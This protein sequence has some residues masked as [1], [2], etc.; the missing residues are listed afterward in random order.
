MG[1]KIIIYKDNKFYKEENLK[2]NWE[3]FIYKWGNIES[4]SYFFEI[5]NEE[6]DVISGVTYS[7]TAPFAKR[8]EAV[9]DEDLPPKS[10][11]GFQKGIDIYVEYYPSKKTISFTKM[12]FYRMNLDIADF[13]LEKADKVEI[14][15]NF[16][17]WK[18]DTEPI[19]HFEGTNYEVILA[20]PEGVYEYKYLIDGKWYPENE[21]KKLIVGENGALF[22]QGDLGTGKFVYEAIDKKNSDE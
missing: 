10:I 7:H 9:V 12:K 4:G 17:N 1:Y 18:P 19:H 3:N 5:K 11:T 16:N 20:S 8:F 22:P 2:Q 13:G 14:A 21:N 15:G 6:A